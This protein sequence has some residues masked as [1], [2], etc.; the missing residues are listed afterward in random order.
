MSDETDIIERHAEATTSGIMTALKPYLPYIV[1][2]IVGGG[3]V[4][5]SHSDAHNQ[6]QVAENHAESGTNWIGQ[7][8]EHHTIRE[9][10]LQTQINT[11]S[12]QVTFLMSQTKEPK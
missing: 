3:A 9:D 11:L 1:S 12:N 4:A 2:L 6:A 8:F 10:A 5:R 7:D